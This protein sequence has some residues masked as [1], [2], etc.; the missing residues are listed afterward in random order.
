MSYR[1]RPSDG[2]NG[3]SAKDRITTFCVGVQTSVFQEAIRS[4]VKMALG[5]VRSVQSF[6]LT[7]GACLRTPREVVRGPI[8]A[9]RAGL[10]RS[11]FR[12]LSGVVMPILMSDAAE[13][14]RR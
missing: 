9:L 13:S 11:A 12:Y 6:R 1:V 14:R 4:Y 8:A 3:A 5:Q 2:S 7:G 10:S